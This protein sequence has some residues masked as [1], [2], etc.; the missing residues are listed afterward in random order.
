MKNQSK[1]LII[2]TIL[3]ELLYI[4]IKTTKNLC[5]PGD[6]TDKRVF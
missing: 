2:K 4:R 5:Y 6:L 3:L 1:I